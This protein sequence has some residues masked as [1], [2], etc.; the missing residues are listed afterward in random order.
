VAK[1]KRLPLDTYIYTAVIEA[2]AKS[3]MWQKALC[4]FEEMQAVGLLPS[5]VTYSVMITACGN[6]GQWEKSMEFLDLMRKRGMQVNLITNNAAI[7]ALAKA[8]KQRQLSNS[9]AEKN[10]QLSRK[11]LELLKQ[12]QTDG[13]EPDGFSYTSAISCCGSDGMW[14]DAL[15]LFEAM[16]RGGPRTSPNKIAYTA[17]I[18]SAGK[19]G[20][21]DHAIRL[22]R[23]MSEQGL[24]PDIVAY[25]ALFSALRVGKRADV[26]CELWK[27]LC[28]NVEFDEA[29]II[30]PTVARARARAYASVKPDIITLSEAI[31]TVSSVSN[32]EISHK[33]ID[34]I[35]AEAVQLGIV[36]NSDPM[37]L[38]KKVD[39]S[40]MS[41]PVARAACRFVLQR[42]TATPTDAVREL[43]FIT[44]VGVSTLRREPTQVNP[45]TKT[46]LRDYMREVLLTDFHIPFDFFSV[47]ASHR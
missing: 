33:L 12:M 38:N 43:A 4:I 47:V 20:Q 5:E 15:N 37:D 39:L 6:G 7:A 3:K 42:I 19:S 34:D 18:S 1:D 10:N 46:S 35:F 27:E 16:R 25:N 28:G 14:Q 11:A 24:A 2:V 30:R 9:I 21:V 36:L 22:F 41:F 40:G 45:Q 23:E 13:I 44:G 8:A 17:A 29:A 31:A 26:A 32:D